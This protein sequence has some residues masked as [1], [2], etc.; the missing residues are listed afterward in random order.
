M[1]VWQDFMFANLDYPIADEDFRALVE[2]EAAA[3]A[4]RASAGGRALA[5]LCGNSEVEQ[6]VAMLGLDPELGRG[7]LFGE[8]LPACARGRRR[9]TPSTCPRRRAAATCRSARTAAS[10]TTSASAAT[11]GRSRTRAAADVRFASECLAFANVP[12]TRSSG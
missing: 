10:R 7:E 2:A 5:V 6:Q 8:L 4:R 3:G 11:A 12:R 9:R 1:L